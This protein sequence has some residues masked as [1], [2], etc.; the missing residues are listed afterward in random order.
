[1]SDNE[2]PKLDENA[3]PKPTDDKTDKPDENGLLEAGRNLLK[4]ER[5]ARKNAE[6]DLAALQ[7]R[8]EEIEGKDKSDVE[9]LTGERDKL[10]K[11]AESA[12]QRAREKAGKASVFEAARKANAVSANAVYA[13]VRDQLDFDDDDEPTNADVL[14]AAAKKAEPSLFQA[15]AGS[16]DGGKGGELG[17]PEFKN[18]TERLSYAYG[19]RVASR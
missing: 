9:R 3:N 7:R 2:N 8:I 18:A 11:D 15:T 13:L 16:G 19:Q 5:D 17:K 4:T 6:R 14:I 1:M 10:A 12:I